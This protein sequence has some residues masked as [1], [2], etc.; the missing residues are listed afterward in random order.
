[1]KFVDVIGFNLLVKPSFFV[2]VQNVDGG[3]DNIYEGKVFNCH[4]NP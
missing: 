1:V 2:G 3:Y 4:P